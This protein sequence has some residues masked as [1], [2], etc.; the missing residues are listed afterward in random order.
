MFGDNAVAIALALAAGTSWALS[1]LCVR[2]GVHHISTAQ[3]TLVS[4]L[5]G[6]AMTAVLVLLLQADD[7]RSI[8]LA[9]AAGFALV[10]IFNFPLGRFLNYLSIQYLGVARST[11]IVA[12]SPLFGIVFA[13][14]F[15]GETLDL[16]T[17][18]GAGLVLGGIYLTMGSGAGSDS[19]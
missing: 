12:A 10:G 4:L 3:G 6:L 9:G 18:A 16:K 14:V 5:V 2:F 11:P 15:L 7:L 1:S 8:S 13:L 17:I 19:A